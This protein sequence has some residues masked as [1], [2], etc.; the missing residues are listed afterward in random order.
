MARRLFRRAALLALVVAMLALPIAVSGAGPAWEQLDDVPAPERQEVSYVELGGMLYL[1]GGNHTDHQ[2]YNPATRQWTNVAP[3]PAAFFGVDHVH[4]VAVGDKIVY[5]GGVE[6]WDPPNTVGAVAVYTP[7]S[8]GQGTFTTGD[9][10]LRP[11]GAGGVAVWNGKVIY[12]GGLSETNGAVAWVDM[13]DPQTKSWTQLE[14]MPRP[15]DHF[16]AAVAGGKLYAVGGRNTT[17]GSSSGSFNVHSPYAEVDV[18][19]LA[20]GDWEENVT[21][22]P[23]PRG[24]HGV[25]AI[26]S[27]IYAIGGE[28]VA[29]GTSVTGIV[30]AYNART[31]EWTDRASLM[32]PRH[33]I[34]AAVHNKTIFVAAGGEEEYADNT[35]A[36][37]ESLAIG[38]DPDCW[39]GAPDPGGGDPG[40]G[41]PGGAGP[42]TGAPSGSAPIAPQ[43]P[44]TAGGGANRPT[45]PTATA[46][47]ESLSVSPRRLRLTGRRRG[48]TVRF[49]LSKATTVRFVVQRARSRGWRRVGKLKRQGTAG[50]N[51]FRFRGRVGR[52]SLRPGRYRLVASIPGS[53]DRP[54]R[55]AFRV[56]R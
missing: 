9:S 39:D 21:S 31:G 53:D 24:G 4:G 29:G 20:S 11:R 26:G 52:R 3:L 42:G 32:T 25:A 16:Q 10:M 27:C 51:R 44:G 34:Q 17:I 49:M 46:K 33:G 22:I 47:L 40:G 30:E 28:G 23:T 1:A 35:T 54:L 7:G 13:Y 36:A 43:V 6:K 56:V 19:D 37:H 38:H 50:A 14:D 8:G 41:D 12:A 15:R 5:I 45:A 48:T 2:R 55:K 18:L